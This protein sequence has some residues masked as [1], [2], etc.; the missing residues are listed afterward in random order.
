MKLHFEYPHSCLKCHS[1]NLTY[2]YGW[3]GK[4]IATYPAMPSIVTVFSRVLTI[5]F[6]TTIHGKESNYQ[7][8][9]EAYISVYPALSE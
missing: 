5:R 4:V 3:S 7:C 1:V 9:A 2:C 6:I 8:L